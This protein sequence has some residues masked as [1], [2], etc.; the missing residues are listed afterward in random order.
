MTGRDFLSAANELEATEGLGPWIALMR[1]LTATMRTMDL[2]APLEPALARAESHWFGQPSDLSEVKAAVW[3]F[4]DAL[5]P[6]GADL[7]TS[8]G[9]VARA[10]LCVL[11][12]AG[13][14]EARSMTAE[15]F[16]EMTQDRQ[17]QG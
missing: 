5:G 3:R 4:I 14:D 1:V 7:A 17:G 15:W 6:A 16:A 12:P 8:E 13:D 10:L 2:P 11:E 9:R